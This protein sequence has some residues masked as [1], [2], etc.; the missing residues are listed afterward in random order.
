MAKAKTT[1]T[2][3]KKTK[4]AKK[5]TT[6]AKKVKLGQNVKV[7]YKGTLDDGTIFDNSRDREET[8]DFELGSGNLIPAFQK[9][10]VGMKTGE[11]KAFKVTCDD[12][13]GQHDPDGLVEVPK[14]AFPE[15]YPFRVGDAVLGSTPDGQSIRATISSVADDTV[16]L[17]H[18]H[19]L[20]GKDLNFEVELIEIQ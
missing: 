7:H 17:D 13:Y 6:R 20:A 1:S 3:K 5:K 12:A 10:I 15:D 2:A 9:E 18:N 16:V 19:P 11:T 8:L 14:E 4:T